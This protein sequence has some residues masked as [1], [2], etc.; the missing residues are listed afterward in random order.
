MLIV[1]V[2]WLNVVFSMMFVVLWLIFG[3]FLSVL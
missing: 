2:G 3:R 1:I